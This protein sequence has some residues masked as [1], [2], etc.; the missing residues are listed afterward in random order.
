MSVA[1]HAG[2]ALARAMLSLEGLSC[3]DA[4]GERFFLPFAESA[5][6]VS[7][8]TLPGGQWEFT[9]DTLMAV[10]IVENLRIH[11][12]IVQ[13]PLA[14]HFAKLYSPHRGYGQ[15][16]HKLMDLISRQGGPSWRVHAPALFGGEGSFGNGSAM[17]VTPLGAYFADDLDQVVAQASLSAMPTHSHPEAHAG[18]I[19]TALA[20][21]I[22]WQTR[23]HAPPAPA[24]FLQSIHDRTPAGEV[25]SGIAEAISLKTGT[26]TQEAA[27]ALGNGSQITAMDT[28]PF[29]LWAAATFLHSYEEALWQTVSANGDR[30]TNCAMVGGIVVMRTGISGIPSEWRRRRELLGPLFLHA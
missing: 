1:P 19:A 10:S 15:A 12:R 11:G 14:E 23:D 28:V 5:I 25:S 24:E 17:R 27:T 29:V 13:D 4:F 6:M 16:M 26:S 20:A 9:D 2:D 7:K 30:D 3:G 18:A 21:A 22:A 8:R